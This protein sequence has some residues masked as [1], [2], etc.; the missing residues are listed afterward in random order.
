[1][2][3]QQEEALSVEEEGPAW[4]AA[5]HRD[6][7]GSLKDE[8]HMFQVLGSEGLGNTNTVTENAA[9]GPPAPRTDP[10]R[11]RPARRQQPCRVLPAICS[12][13]SR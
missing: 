11:K 9:P 1:M 13:P 10:H 7:D 5:Q 6:E 3:Q 4:E 8:P 12:H 2:L